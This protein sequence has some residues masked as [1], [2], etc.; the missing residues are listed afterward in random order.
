M[1]VERA[2]HS[3]RKSGIICQATGFGHWYHEWT[4]HCLKT[5]LILSISS[6]SCD[7]YLYFFVLCMLLVSYYRLYFNNVSVDYISLCFSHITLAIVLY[8]F[9]FFYYCTYFVL[10]LTQ[11]Y[12]LHKSLVGNPESIFVNL[13]WVLPKN[14]QGKLK[15]KISNNK[16]YMGVIFLLLEL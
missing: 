3:E 9:V 15:Y 5:L 8:F 14:L 7:T 13:F 12:Y 6:L 2:S 11:Y 16:Q 10:Q 4:L 1:Q